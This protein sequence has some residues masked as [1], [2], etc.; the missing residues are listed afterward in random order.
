M[1]NRDALL[2]ELSKLSDEKLAHALL[3][4][5]CNYC[6]NYYEDWSQDFCH[7]SI[8]ESSCEQGVIEWLKAEEGTDLQTLH[9]KKYHSCKSPEHARM[10]RKLVNDLWKAGVVQVAS[11]NCTWCHRPTC[12]NCLVLPSFINGQWR[13]MERG[14][15]RRI[16]LY[17]CLRELVKRSDCPDEIKQPL[18]EAI[19]HVET[20]SKS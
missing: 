2:A 8:N 15:D 5:K 7:R 13:V 12:E 9:R 19:A 6:S 11:D 3:Y 18:Y 14:N 20:L 17:D 16:S 10:L 4:Y 1:T